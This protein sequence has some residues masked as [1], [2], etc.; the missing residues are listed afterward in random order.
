MKLKVYNKKVID[1]VWENTQ[2][3]SVNAPKK[4]KKKQQK[5]NSVVIF[6][7]YKLYNL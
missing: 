1:F 7:P 2:A 5:K 6:S 3:R 4:T